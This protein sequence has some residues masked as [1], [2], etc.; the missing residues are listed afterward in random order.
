MDKEYIESQ[1]RQIVKE[2]K[3]SVDETERWNLRNRMARLE[4]TAGEIFG[5]DYMDDIHNQYTGQMR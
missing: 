3:C 1:Y 4:R 2:W 5:Y